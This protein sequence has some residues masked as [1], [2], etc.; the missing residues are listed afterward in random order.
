[1]V[2]LGELAELGN[3]YLCKCLEYKHSIKNYT[4]YD[5]MLIWQ[6]NPLN[7]KGMYTPPPLRFI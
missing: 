3:L 2:R 6:L 5:K 4:N 1:M 7:R